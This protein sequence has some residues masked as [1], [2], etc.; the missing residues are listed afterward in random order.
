M[1]EKGHLIKNCLYKELRIEVN[2]G[3]SKESDEIGSR[4]VK[5]K[6]ENEQRLLEL[7][8]E[9]REVRKREREIRKEIGKIE[10]NRR[11][12]QCK[13]KGHE[14]KDCKEIKDVEMTLKEMENCLKKYGKESIWREI[15]EEIETENKNKSIMN[16]RIK[17]PLEEM[18]VVKEGRK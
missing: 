15:F 2:D 1:G 9:L 12:Y 7:R 17:V 6:T 14:M 11:C 8:K 3:K 13:K 18:K 10:G 16:I 4:K 5:K